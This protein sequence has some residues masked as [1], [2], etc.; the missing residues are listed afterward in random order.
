MFQVL[1]S[2][3]DIELFAHILDIVVPPL[4]TTRKEYSRESARHRA[5]ADALEKQEDHIEAFKE[6]ISRINRDIE[7][8]P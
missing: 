1:L 5:F 2:K 8:A 3:N 7:H 4:V 6:L